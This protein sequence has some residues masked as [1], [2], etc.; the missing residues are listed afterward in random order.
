[1]KIKFPKA[2]KM[3]KKLFVG[4]V[5]PVLP[6]INPALTICQPI[7]GKESNRRIFTRYFLTLYIPRIPRVAIVKLVHY[8]FPPSL[9][10]LIG[11]GS[12]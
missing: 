3:E 4:V 10:F 2:K 7:L 1:M 9:S 6:E 8:T 12:V 5:S 11:N